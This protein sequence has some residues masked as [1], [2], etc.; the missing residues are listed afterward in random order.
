MIRQSMKKRILI[1]I[2]ILTLLLSG[3][4]TFANSYGEASAGEACK[5]L[6]WGLDKKVSVGGVFQGTSNEDSAN[7]KWTAE[8]L[9]RDSARFTT[10]YGEGPGTW[11]YA[12]TTDRGKGVEGYDSVK[13]KLEENRGCVT[14]DFI[15]NFFLYTSSVITLITSSI[16]LKLV[17]RDYM[18]ETIMNIVGG[19]NDSSEGLISIF[20][21]SFYMPLIVI[22]VLIMAFIIIYK[23]L[24]QFKFREALNS[25]IWTL[26]AFI[27]G[28]ALMLNPQIL[29]SVPQAATSTITSCVMGALSGQNCLTGDVATPSIITG[30]E[31]ASSVG[32]EGS[33]A[34]SAVN[35]LNCTI[36]KSFVLEPWAE[37]QFGAP[38][39]ELYTKDP[40]KGGDTWRNL[41][42]GQADKYCVNFTSN[43]SYKDSIA[44]GKPVM[45]GPREEICNVALYHLFVKTNME[46]PISQGDNSYEDGWTTDDTGSYDKRWYDIIVPA[47]SDNSTWR[48]WSG[49]GQFGSRVGAAFMGNIAAFASATVLLLLAVFAGAYK[50]IG[51]VLMAFAPVFLLLAIEPTR[52]RRIFLGWLETLI[53]SIL[54]YFAIT[55]LIVVAL[56][57]YAGM[58]ASTSSAMTFVGVIVLTFAL[59]MY[60][61]EI[62]NLI[63]ASNMG[64]QR[65]SN[66][67]NELGS[68]AA[69]KTKDGAT[70]TA[71]GALGG[72]LGRLSER[73]RAV[74]AR[75]ATIEDLQR[76][77]NA[78]T[79][80]EDKEFYKE[81]MAK[82]QDLLK[83]EGSLAG[84]LVKGTFGGGVESVKRSM[85]RG[86][87]VGA[88]IIQQSDRTATALK[89]EREKKA[90]EA[91]AIR[92]QY[93]D[94]RERAEI[95]AAADLANESE[96]F[97]PRDKQGKAVD[98]EKLQ[99]AIDA[100]YEKLTPPRYLENEDLSEEEKESLDDLVKQVKEGN[101]SDEKLM[102]MVKDD[103]FIKDPNK[104]N[105]VSKEIKA[106]IEAYN[107]LEVEGS[108][109]DIATAVEK[110]MIED[111]HFSEGISK[112]E[113]EFVNTFSAHDHSEM[114]G[115]YKDFMYEAKVPKEE[116]EASAKNMVAAYNANLKANKERITEELKEKDENLY[117][118]AKKDILEA[119][120]VDR[121]SLKEKYEIDDETA[122]SII[123]L[124][125]IEQH[126]ESRGD[127]NEENHRKVLVKKEDKEE[128]RKP[129][130]RREERKPE[131]RREERKP[132][133]RKEK[134]IDSFEDMYQ[135]MLDE[136]EDDVKDE[137]PIDP[138]EEME[139][140]ILER[141]DED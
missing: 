36:W 71:G 25:L 95:L 135:E 52:G 92:K 72:T 138:F 101:L 59:H 99:D 100:E 42:E 60:R 140:E 48:S 77:L 130:E 91:E 124:M 127:K 120:E 74:E 116:I 34:E 73:G 49:D 115:S 43:K 50:V 28:L 90:K 98:P 6:G 24:I 58:I 106:R 111:P 93:E 136:M 126:V 66:K 75:S 82:E 119:G 21:Q 9:F 134:P 40:P 51:L 29:V 64:G 35:S 133:E 114:L 16:T 102:E 121:E 55:V 18:A 19:E 1:L 84:A 17:G 61:K 5:S 54:K 76:K 105:I 80:E 113:K 109:L 78:A 118:K 20:L 39:N 46:D 63:G 122:D 70:T 10:Y 123:D 45:D 22:T 131:E 96:T 11:W 14:M 141:N 57:M 87:G 86:T 83:K 104:Q 85:K 44:S 8:E 23:G 47:A 41:P 97:I 128:E 56:V 33:D 137:S 103:E 107:N 37:V 7:R 108:P 12:D 67:A 125:E 68:W 110:G 112:F 89:A 62:T 88:N 132:E 27:L 139:R 81:Q 30:P 94:E 65:L 117:K 3:I 26:G 31:C 13:S 15:P 53:S 38:Y 69:K 129:E 4:S 2:A 79:S 32:A